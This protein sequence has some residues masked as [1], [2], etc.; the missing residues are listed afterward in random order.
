MSMLE[1]GAYTAIVRS[2]DN[3]NGVALVEVYTLH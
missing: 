2:H 3:T 1:P